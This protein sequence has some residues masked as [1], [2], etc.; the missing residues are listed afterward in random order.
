V[1]IAYRETRSESEKIVIVPSESKDFKKLVNSFNLGFEIRCGRQV[2]VS[3]GSSTELTFLPRTTFFNCSQT[4]L[5]SGID[6]GTQIDLN[7]DVVALKIDVV[8][9]Y[10]RI[11][12]KTFN[13]RA[14]T[15]Y[16]V[17]TELPIPYTIAP[18]QLRDT[19]MRNSTEENDT[20]L[21]DK[22]PIDAL[23]L[24][25]VRAIEKL[26]SKKLE[27]RL[28][29]G[30]KYACAVTHDVDTE[31]GMLRGRLLKKLE[32]KYDIQSAWYVPSRHYRLHIETL[33]ALANYGEIGAHGTKHCGNLCGMSEKKLV[34]EF[35]E[36]KH[37]LEK[38]TNRP[39]YGF[40]A[41]LLQHNLNMLQALK[42][43][44]Y[45]YD[46]SVPTWEPK[47]PRT[48]RPHGI[49]TAFPVIVKGQSELPVSAVQD[50][51]LL[52]VLNLSPREA[53]SRWC[54]T[55]EEIKEVGGCCAFLSHPEY[56]LFDEE[57]IAKYEELLNLVADDRECWISTPR[58]LTDAFEN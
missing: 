40:R 30:K 16:R 29:K 54:S 46:S 2:I 1:T 35:Q 18:K 43:A 22:L 55:I 14:S 28:W 49:G 5:A 31:K 58:E 3:A 27:K 53:I 33:R 50:H 13:A 9:E 8:D 34:K 39:V 48:M 24:I 37:T 56:K 41:P 57:G 23:R 17:L 45:K 36:A 38:M 12:G 51:Q 52:Y 21:R 26:S 11:L 10:R 44:G 20:S 19:I 6:V 7:D 15:R 4:E 25:L 32:E 42:E 47:H